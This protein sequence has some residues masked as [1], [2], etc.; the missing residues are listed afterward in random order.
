[1]SH[2]D[3]TFINNSSQLTNKDTIF[4]KV[5]A[6]I[7]ETDDIL[8]CGELKSVLK[9][10]KERSKNLLSIVKKSNQVE[11][12]SKI[13]SKKPFFNKIANHIETCKD[14]RIDYEEEFTKRN[15]QNMEELTKIVFSNSKKQNKSEHDLLKSVSVLENNSYEL[16]NGLRPNLYR[17]SNSYFNIFNQFASNKIV[18]KNALDHQVPSGEANRNQLTNDIEIIDLTL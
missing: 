11:E 16:G 8:I 6:V 5:K 7:D 2:E 1:M 18:N 9:E 10:N 4:K 13:V 15:L 3:D 12:L 14:T 17:N